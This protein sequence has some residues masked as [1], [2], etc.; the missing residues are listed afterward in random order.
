[1]S[2]FLTAKDLKE[3]ASIVS[4]LANLGFKP[5]RK[6]GRELLYKSMLG[7]DDTGSSLS[8]D[9]ALGVW[10]DH[11]TRKGGNLI[12]FGLALWRHLSYDE[13]IQKLQET[14]AK[15]STEK[16]LTRPRKAIKIPDYIVEEI[17][18]IGANPVITNYLKGRGVFKA[19]GSELNEV[20]YYAEDQKGVRKHFFSAGWK[21]ENGGWEIRNKYFKGCIGHRGL[22]FLE[23]HKKNLAIFD[24][25]LN[26]LGWKT[27]NPAADESIII[28]NSLALL[29]IG[30]ERAKAFSAIGLYLARDQPG[31]QATSEFIKT[32]PYASDR[33]S[34]YSGFHDYNDKLAAGIIL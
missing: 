13:V 26:Y 17:R 14:C 24:N 16:K 5:A 1:M 30:I 2:L 10:F 3:Q 8:V 15:V 25:F 32:L 19:A 33:S 12:D 6:N 21:N 27:E 20:Y 31:H 29:R 28:L 18:D 11:G 7:K 23:G 4:L 34:A 22:N 9:D